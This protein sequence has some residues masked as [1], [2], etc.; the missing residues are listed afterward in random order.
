MHHFL[1]YRK[2]IWCDTNIWFI[3][4]DWISRIQRKLKI[5]RVATGHGQKMSFYCFCH[6][7]W[8]S[9][10]RLSSNAPHWKLTLGLRARLRH[11]YNE[12]KTAVWALNETG[13]F[14]INFETLIL[15]TVITNDPSTLA[16]KGTRSPT[17]NCSLLN[18]I[19]ANFL[20]DAR[21]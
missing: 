9:F 7:A 14:W 8:I 21:A 15:P 2:N 6:F 1:L 16:N 3:R 13:R 4:I 18:R 10:N 11:A 19:N 5:E 12:D 17:W 20:S